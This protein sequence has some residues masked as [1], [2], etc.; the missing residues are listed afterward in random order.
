MGQ[1]AQM[2]PK[3]FAGAQFFGSLLEAQGI[4]A[5]GESAAAAARF[6]ARLSEEEGLR[7]QARLRG[8]GARYLASRAVAANKAGLALEGTALDA[9]V[10]DAET[11]EREALQARLQGRQAAQLERAGGRVARSSARL[12]AG[13]TILGGA[14]RAGGTYYQ[15][16]YPSGAPP[17]RK[18]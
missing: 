12:A 13:A 17:K 16:R 3:V 8:E 5:E 9:L 15:L 6:N 1:F 2:A 18:T 4:R 11:I 10:A 7:E 14:A